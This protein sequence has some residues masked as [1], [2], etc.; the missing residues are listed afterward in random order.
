LARRQ[1]TQDF[2]GIFMFTSLRKFYAFAQPVIVSCP[3]LRQADL[4]PQ[5]V[6]AGE[7]SIQGGVAS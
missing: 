6:R 4:N 2:G 5:A 1:K 7:N 3:L